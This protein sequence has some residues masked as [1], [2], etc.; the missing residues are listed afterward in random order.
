MDPGVVAGAYAAETVVEGAVGA[1]FAIAKSTMQLKAT[2]K[3]IRTGNPLPRS[4]HSLS[5][6]KGKA[7]VFGGEE[8]P[9]EPVRNDM[10]IYTLP[11]SGVSEADYKQIAAEANPGEGEIP[12][13]RVGHT[14]N[15]IGDRIYVFGGRGGKAMQPW[16]EKGR[17]WVYDTRLNSWSFLDPLSGSP[18]PAARSYHASAATMHP[19]K[20]VQLNADNPA[21]SPDPE[22]QGTIFVHGGCPASGRLADVWAFDLGTRMWSPYPNAPG[23]ARGGPSLTF[24][25]NRL[26]RF[27]GFDGKEELGGLDYL[28]LSVSD[29]S[30]TGDKGELTIVQP[31][32]KWEAVIPP[33]ATQRP[34]NRSVAGLQPITTGQGRNYL[35][36]FL[37]EG[38]PS[39]LGHEGAGKFYNDVWCYQSRSDG[40]T[41]AS[42]KDATRKLVGAKTGEGSWA[43]VEIP[44]ASMAEGEHE[45]PG[46]R[47]WFASAQVHDLDRASVV[48]WG[49]IKSDNIRA[50]D[51]WI[52]TVE[53]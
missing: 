30:D 39:S 25:Q 18:Y 49:G 6:I 37:G 53:V 3:R 5:V 36:L 50:G 52:L 10:H 19:R 17:V 35:L 45:H 1:G 31:T 44:E 20:R 24:T 8:Q 34:G 51:C 41:A 13:S 14:A 26:Y 16:E 15:A 48:L 43:R 28:D 40:M 46:P 21:G 11:S 2:W 22:V 33:S 27:G 7:Y 9:R 4:S 42:F 23:P 32:G 38:D 29:I 47:G 12:P